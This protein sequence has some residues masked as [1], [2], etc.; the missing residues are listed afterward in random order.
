VTSN[1]FLRR[2]LGEDAAVDPAAVAEAPPEQTPQRPSAETPPAS[3]DPDVA[4]STQELVQQ[5]QKGDHMAVAARLMFTPASY[6]DFV[7]L[8]FIIGREG[9]LELGQLLD[10]L[11]DTEGVEPPQT[12][13][14]YADLL[15]RAAGA[16]HE[17]EVL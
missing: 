4:P 11:A 3:A 1:P 5:W 16:D 2:L 7:D 14:Q 13:P 15:S 12:P 10:E 17:E 9:G 6:K 8:C